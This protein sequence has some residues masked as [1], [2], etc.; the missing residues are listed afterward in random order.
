MLS[1]SFDFSGPDNLLSASIIWT[2][3]R[4]I[5]WSTMYVSSG[6]IPLACVRSIFTLDVIFCHL[7]QLVEGDLQPFVPAAIKIKLILHRAVLRSALYSAYLVS[8]IFSYNSNHGQCCFDC[9][10]IFPHLALIFFGV[11]VKELSCQCWE[12]LMVFHFGGP[13]FFGVKEVV[14]NPWTVFGHLDVEVLQVP[15]LN[16]IELP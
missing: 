1:F 8:H 14:V 6:L 5:N 11:V 3:L 2:W 13:S 4:L 9:C 7:T 15:V 12:G 10:R 16:I